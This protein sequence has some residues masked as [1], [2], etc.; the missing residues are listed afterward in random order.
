MHRFNWLLEEVGDESSAEKSTVERSCQT[1][2]GNPS[3]CAKTVQLD[4]RLREAPE[5]T[6]VL[7]PDRGLKWTAEE[8]SRATEAAEGKLLSV[9]FVL[10]PLLWF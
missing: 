2:C 9:D 7:W 5:M 3:L 10:G 6:P 4:E 1:P 8:Q